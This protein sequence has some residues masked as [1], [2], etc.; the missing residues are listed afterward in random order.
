MSGNT[1][2]KTRALKNSALAGLH[3]AINFC[4]EAGIEM[5]IVPMYNTGDDTYI[6]IKDKEVVFSE[7]TLKVRTNDEEN[8]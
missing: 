1:N 2:S 7:G 4:I 3:I 8:K 6:V 5:G